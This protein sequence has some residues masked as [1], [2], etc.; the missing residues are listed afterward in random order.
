M[1]SRTETE[2]H[3]ANEGYIAMWVE[4]ARCDEPPPFDMV[5]SLAPRLLELDEG[6]RNRAARR[7]YF[8]ADFRLDDG[9]WWQSHLDGRGDIPEAPWASRFPRSAA[10]E[11]A[12][13]SLTLA[14]HTAGTRLAESGV[15]FGVSPEVTRVLRRMK[16]EDLERLADLRID[17]MRPRWENR[18]GMWRRLLDA[19]KSGETQA[20]N[21]VDRLAGQLLATDLMRK[22]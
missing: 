6:A 2:L 13:R 16:L 7:S 20:L 17:I 1:D 22:R 19:A 15:S 10:V 8:L 9:P 18:L 21:Y 4:M 12:R 11:L 3:S 14:W 5:K